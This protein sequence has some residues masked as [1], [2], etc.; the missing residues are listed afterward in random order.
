MRSLIIIAILFVVVMWILSSKKYT[1]TVIYTADTP[2]F[3]STP[4]Y[5]RHSYSPHHYRRH[6]FY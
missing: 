5:Y 3:Y 1:P 2:I 4:H 6:R